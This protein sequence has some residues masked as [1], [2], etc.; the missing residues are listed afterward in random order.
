[1]TATPIVPHSFGQLLVYYL[2]RFNRRALRRLKLVDLA[3]LLV[4][5]AAYGLDRIDR[6][7]EWTWMYM[8]VARKGSG[9]E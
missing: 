5:A 6:A 2:Y 1:M 4:Q 3:G 8:V 9:H 7:E